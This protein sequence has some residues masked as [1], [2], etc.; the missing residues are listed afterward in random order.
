MPNGGAVISVLLGARE[1]KVQP[2]DLSGQPLSAAKHVETGRGGAAAILDSC[3]A[4]ASSLLDSMDPTPVQL[5]ATGVALD[6]DARDLE[7]PEYF[8]GRPIVIDSALGAIAT[9]EALS[10]TPRPQNMLF[11]DVGKTIDCA[12]L[13]HGRTLGV[14]R[15]SKGAFG[16]TPVKG[17]SAKS[18][19]VLACT[20]GIMNCLQAIAGEEAIIASLSSDSQNEPDAISEAAR[21]TDPAAISALRQAGRDIG[22]TLLGSIHL[23][24]PEVIT[25]RTRWP[26]ATDLLLAGLK[27]AVYAGG[28]PAVTENLVLASSK[29]GSPA[30]GIALRAMDAGLAVEPVDRLLSAP[31]SLSGQQTRRPAQCDFTDRQRAPQLT[32]RG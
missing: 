17:K 28:A 13:I 8:G 3:L 6:E 27:E 9:A 12:V 10:R 30:T 18:M 4:S 26:G 24:R 22:D 5:I 20:C 21:R 23:F 7:W 16:H 32:G 11:L 15:T 2:F 1:A 14:L 31:P 19:P 25:V 29:T